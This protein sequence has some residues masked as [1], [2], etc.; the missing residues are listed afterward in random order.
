MLAYRSVRTTTEQG[1]EG[2]GASRRTICTPI[3]I[4]TYFA[5]ESLGEEPLL[6]GIVLVLAA[7][8]E[9]IGMLR[10]AEIGSVEI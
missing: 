2:G 6:A 9:G 5:K 3:L 4:Q 7:H 8:H 1:G 10:S